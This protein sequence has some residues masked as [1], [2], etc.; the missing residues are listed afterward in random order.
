MRV[1]VVVAHPLDEAFAKV[2]ARRICATL[3]RR[4]IKA[5]LLD[6]YAEDFDLRLSVEERRGYFASPYD[7]SAVAPYVERLRAAEKLVLVFPQWWFDVP[8]I[9]KG[10]FDRVFAPGVAFDHGT[11]GAGL[12]PRLTHMQAIWV[13]STT[14]SPWWIVRLY[15]GDPVRRQIKLGVRSFINPKAK[16]RMLSLHDMDRMTEARGKAFLEKLE[17][18]FQRF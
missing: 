11:G 7:F 15:M 4:G 1:L 17:R 6:L 8:A 9:L 13:V 16:F 5:D 12:V 2:A 10:F 14:G 18:A 3:E